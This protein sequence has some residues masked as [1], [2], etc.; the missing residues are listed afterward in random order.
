MRVKD[1]LTIILEKI[2]YNFN[3][4][5]NSIENK[6][7]INE[8]KNIK[9][10]DSYPNIQE[11]SFVISNKNYLREYIIQKK[12]LKYECCRCGLSSWQNNPLLL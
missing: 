3:I 5:D 6:I 8:N 10:E 11:E 4:I 2:M 12:L 1:I 9:Y 7:S